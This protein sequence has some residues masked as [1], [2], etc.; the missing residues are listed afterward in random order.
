MK[1]LYISVHGT[2]ERQ[3]LQLFTEM[4]HECF[5][6]GEY[7]IPEVRPEEEYLHKRPGIVGMQRH[8]ELEQFV[9]GHPDTNIA[10]EL[11]D[12]CDAVMV[13]HDPNIIVMN[14]DKFKA[15]G[16]PI[17]WRSIGQSTANCENQLRRMRYDG[18]HIVRMSPREKGILGYMGEDAIIR[19]YAD[20]EDNEGWNGNT[21]R[22]INI[23]QSLLGRRVFC[24][25]DQI[26]SIMNGFPSLV[27]GSGNNDL[28][29][30]NGGELPYDL[31]IG[32]LRDNRAF[33]YGGTFPSPYTLSLI[34]A[35]FVGIPVVAIDASLAEDIAVAPQDKYNYYEM[36]DIIEHGENG[37]ISGSINELRDCVHQ[38]LEDH[39]LAKRM[40]DKG[41][42]TAVR[43]FGKDKI[44]EQWEN[45]LNM[46]LL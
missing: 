37:F 2:L 3:E 45:F 4:G 14:W 27:Y 15:S 30:L 39:E 33:I 19:F 40:S 44:R 32:A 34:D 13:M 7:R 36:G 12:W 8:E 20:I 17:I 46:V 29:G 16:K 25:Y 10:Q 28:G 24:H 42:K 43:L 31:L 21:K 9:K 26:T 18:M 6:T 5:S 41:K 23:T 22:V 35:M 38:L 1:L 11:I